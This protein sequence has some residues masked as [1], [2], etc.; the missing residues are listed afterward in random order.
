MGP[1]E[2]A[3]V[4]LSLMIFS[5][6]TPRSTYSAATQ[7]PSRFG[8]S[9]PVRD[10]FLHIILF[11]TNWRSGA[12]SVLQQVV[13]NGGNTQPPLFKRAMTSSTFLPFQYKYDDPIPEVLPLLAV[14]HQLLTAPSELTG[15]LYARHRE[16]ELYLRGC[17]LLPSRSGSCR[18]GTRKRGAKRSGRVLWR[19][20]VRAG[21]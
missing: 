10:V 2:R 20:P 7:K 14:F 15:N 8:V 17:R 13:A 9:Q 1:E 11:R 6:R 4:S 3:L 18:F 19:I 5:L 12:G 16:R 21:C